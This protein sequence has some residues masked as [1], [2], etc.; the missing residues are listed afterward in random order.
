M[1]YQLIINILI[2][3]G[4]GL[5]PINAT[6]AGSV[7][8]SETEGKE[9]LKVQ[10]VDV[11]LN[12]YQTTVAEI[13]QTVTSG[14]Y[15]NGAELIKKIPKNAKFDRA[16][17]KDLCLSAARIAFAMAK[18]RRAYSWLERL[19]QVDASAKLD[20]VIDPPEAF[21]VWAEVVQ[22]NVAKERQ[23]V[24]KNSGADI[25]QDE[26]FD[27]RQ[28]DL[29]RQR[30]SFWIGLMP[31]GIGHF[32]IGDYENGALFITA[33]GLGIYSKPFFEGREKVKV[34]SML[35]AKDTNLPI[36]FATL[37]AMSMWGYAIL[38]LVPILQTRD[39]YRTEMARRT[40]VYFPFGVGQAKNGDLFK[41]AALGGVQSALLLYGLSAK[42]EV[43]RQTAVN[44]FMCAYVYGILDGWLHHR[45]LV[46]T[47]AD[48]ESSP[49][50]LSWSLSPEF[51][52]DNGF[53]MRFAVQIK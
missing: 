44:V 5:S 38:D 43:Q 23:E 52:K 14:D 27:S 48:L 18:K 29:L 7:N 47:K 50:A 24:A 46:N 28:H 19:Y 16:T 53:A 40:L 11:E 4:L 42:H 15:K 49:Q 32:D 37:S 45:S 36:I 2:V 25:R 31:F 3:I 26:D 21:A 17:E 12:L 35:R 33:Q 20:P 9:C 51:Y 39:F 13:Q 30:A 22:K 8:C 41:A 6:G 34:K 1:R 10:K